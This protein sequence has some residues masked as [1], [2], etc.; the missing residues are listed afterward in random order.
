[1]EN[2]TTGR[3]SHVALVEYFQKLNDVILTADALIPL[4]LVGIFKEWPSYRPLQ[5]GDSR[6]FAIIGCNCYMS[7]I[8]LQSLHVVNKD[9]VVVT[10]CK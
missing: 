9:R 2:K 7:Y 8:R 3:T 4:S 10:C 1:M 5:N 6:I